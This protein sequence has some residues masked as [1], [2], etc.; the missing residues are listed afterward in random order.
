MRLSKLDEKVLH[1]N[2]NFT[3]AVFGL[4]QLGGALVVTGETMGIITYLEDSGLRSA[5]NKP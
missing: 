1:V 3:C 5:F 2:D 4:R